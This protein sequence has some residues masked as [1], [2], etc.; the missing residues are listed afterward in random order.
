MFHWL[1]KH[2][3]FFAV[4]VFV[5]IA[6]AGLIEIVPNFA[7]ASRP[8]IGTKPYTTL[9]LAGRHVYIKNSCNACHSQLIR[10]FKAETDRYGDYSLSGE[11]AYDRP[12]LWGSKR[13][14]PDL[15][16]VGNYRTTDWHENHMRDPR[17][18]VPGSI[19]PAYA[20]LFENSADVDTAYAE[21]VTVRDFFS[22]PYNQEIPMK[23][24]SKETVVL[25][26]TLAGAQASAL[27]EAK[28]VAADMKDK[29]V[30]DAVSAGQIPEIV[31]LI[32][33]MNSLK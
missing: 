21:Q 16:R 28:L 26:D 5:T 18:V 9:E 24:G 31:A 27:E 11:Y 1:E 7:E 22:V 33:Y 23:D 12:F 4:G 3:F 8:S 2:P 14:G 20:W 25:A 30:Q 19:M 17:S 13:T 10:P 6:F 32:A 29:S 15:M